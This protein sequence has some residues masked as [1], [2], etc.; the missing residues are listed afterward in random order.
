M[1]SWWITIDRNKFSKSNI[2]TAVFPFVRHESLQ[3]GSRLSFS[4]GYWHHLALISGLGDAV[5]SVRPSDAFFIWFRKWVTHIW[6]RKWLDVWLA[7]SHWYLQQ[8]WN[9]VNSILRKSLQCNFNRNSYIINL[10]KTL[11]K[12][13]L[14]FSEISWHLTWRQEK[15]DI[16]IFNRPISQ[17]PEC[18]CFISHN[19]P[20][21]TEMCTFL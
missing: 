21:R 4:G 9:I 2:T 3:I 11:N 18:T 14:I 7:P 12:C 19:A 17:T 15:L 6:F 13:R 16:S 1:G 5:N 10:K 8:F 20:F